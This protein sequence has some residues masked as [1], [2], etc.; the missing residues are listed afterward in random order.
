MLFVVV[1]GPFNFG[2]TATHLLGLLMLV[3]RHRLNR[4]RFQNLFCGFLWVPARK[5]FPHLRLDILDCVAPVV[6]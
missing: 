1:D 2:P 5:R 4:L 3:L 6:G